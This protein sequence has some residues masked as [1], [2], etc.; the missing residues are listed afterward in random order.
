MIPEEI[1]LK[2][3]L[4][5]IDYFYKQEVF[6]LTRMGKSK[7]TYDFDPSHWRKLVEWIKEESNREGL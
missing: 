2:E 1:D 4:K 3:V 6:H 7:G 5:A